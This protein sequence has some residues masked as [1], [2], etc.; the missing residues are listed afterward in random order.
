MIT[1]TP[2]PDK[3]RSFFGPVMIRRI[4]S[5]QLTDEIRRAL[6][7]RSW[8]DLGRKNKKY[9][10]NMIKYK[11]KIMKEEGETRRRCQGR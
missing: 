2:L 7:E 8:E 1:R 4:N 5:V 10:Y 11:G 3:P 9:R 6:V